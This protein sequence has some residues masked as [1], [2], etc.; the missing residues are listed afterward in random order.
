MSGVKVYVAVLNWFNHEATAACVAS[1]LAS[2]HPD[3]TVI[4]VDNGSTND[5]VAVLSARF[6]QVR[7]IA[8]KEN[9]GYAGGNKLAVDVAMH[10]GADLI[11]VLNNDTTVRPDTMRHLVDAY[12]KHGDAV[13]SNTTLMS[14]NPDIV[15]YSGSYG[16]TE[17]SEPSNPYDRLRGKMLADV[18]DGLTDREAR[19]YGH[20]M[21]IP[22][23]V[24]RSCGFMDTEFFMFCEEEDYLKMLR[25][26][27][28]TTR[29]VRNAIMVH[30]SSGSFK[31]NGKVDERLKLTLIYYGKRNGHYMAMKWDAIPRTEI[32]RLRGGWWPLLKFFIRYY[33]SDSAKQAELNE[34][35]MVNLAAVHAFLG[36]RGR[37]LN[38]SDFR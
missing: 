24:I 5:S 12:R 15:H 34:D 16:P 1:L 30:E 23:S 6:P 25:T 22:A 33:I 19:I 13:Y 32:L 14:E 27:G 21:L 9:L 17:A 28:I 35:R 3:H 4:I 20:S 29:Y 31:K 38:P 10:E 37:T 18:W 8:S 11:W 7:I 36:I 26:K 2:D